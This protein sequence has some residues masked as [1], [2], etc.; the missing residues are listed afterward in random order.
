MLDGSC[1]IPALK[2]FLFV[3]TPSC[4]SNFIKN[5]GMD[6]TSL[7]HGVSMYE[8]EQ[9][10]GL[11][12]RQIYENFCDGD[13]SK[14]FAMVVTLANMPYNVTNGF[15]DIFTYIFPSP[16][17]KEDYDKEISAYIEQLILA[18]S[19]DYGRILRGIPVADM[20]ATFCARYRGRDAAYITHYVRNRQITQ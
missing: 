16:T 19:E 10:D 13:T 14:V 20:F 6:I 5:P 8:F 4:F 7:T 12:L 2:F 15:R 17:F 3:M 1:D 9:V 11:T 18:S